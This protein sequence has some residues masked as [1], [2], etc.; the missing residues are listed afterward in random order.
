MGSVRTAKPQHRSK[1]EAVAKHGQILTIVEDV[2]LCERGLLGV[3]RFVLEHCASTDVVEFTFREFAN[4][5]VVSR[6][7]HDPLHHASVDHPIAG[8]GHPSRNV[9]AATV[10]PFTSVAT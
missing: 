10:N 1:K 7:A 6:P 2:A 4:F 3:R 9:L 5:R 8:C